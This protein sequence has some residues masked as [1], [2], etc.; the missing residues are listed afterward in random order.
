MA[1]SIGLHEHRTRV[2]LH[3]PLNDTQEEKAANQILWFLQE[4]RK[5]ASGVKGF[6][7]SVLRPAVF[8]GWWWSAKEKSWCQDHI[9]LLLV[10]YKIDFSDI[11]LPKVVKE[12]KKA[13]RY[14]YRY[15]GR[16]QEEIWVVAHQV[17]RFD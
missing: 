2:V 16:P 4:Q 1:K 11:L 7:H 10:D 13:I 8:R 6:T 5:E 15:Y 3:L 12:L 9:V 14:W 17:F